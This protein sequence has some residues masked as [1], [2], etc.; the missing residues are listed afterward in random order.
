[1]KK[2]ICAV[3]VLAMCLCMGA[4]AEKPCVDRAG[5]AIAL[6]ENIETI[7]TLAPSITQTVLDMSLAEKI[8]A[9]DNYS[10]QYFPEVADLP[11]FDMMNPDCEQ[12]AML[13]PDVIF[14]TGMS[15]SYNDNPFAPLMAMGVSMVVV[16]SSENMEGIKQDIAFI[17]DCLDAGEEAAAL[18]AGM[19]RTLNAVAEIAA[20][21]EEKKTV[22]LELAALP[23]L[24]SF[25]S[26]SFLNEMIELIGAENV[27][28]EY[29]SW[30]SVTEESAV[31]ANPDVIL[32]SV[33]Y[34]EDPVGEILSRPGWEGV[35]AVINGAVYSID[36][37]TSN[38]ANHHVTDALVEMALAIY[39]DAYASLCE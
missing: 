21:I 7:I 2:L 1:M 31:A 29:H 14:V 33:D 12:M 39:P 24:Y 16:P 22:L 38:L 4:L 36:P 9:V 13:E 30:I 37:I 11:R 8:V 18:T 19:D 32:T 3:L 34:I 10:A 17:G 25:G 35:T 26:G 23:R 28:A 5:N 6:P 20:A 15:Y 27:F